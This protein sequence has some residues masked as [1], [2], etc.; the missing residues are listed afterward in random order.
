MSAD[1]PPP[2][3]NSAVL[4]ITG[5]IDR[6]SLPKLSQ[7][8]VSLIEQ[9]RPLGVTCDVG[10]MKSCDL[11]TLD[12]LAHLQLLARRLGCELRVV[13]AT[14]HLMELVEFLGLE[15]LFGLPDQDECD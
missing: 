7:R 11:E 14:R 12:A 8:L 13:Q 10:A 4:V 2:A 9:R 15:R 1:L 3:P 6:G 5:R